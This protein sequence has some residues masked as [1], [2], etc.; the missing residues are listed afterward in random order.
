MLLPKTGH[1]NTLAL[2]LIGVAVSFLALIL[3]LLI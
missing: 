3:L 1:Q 2:G